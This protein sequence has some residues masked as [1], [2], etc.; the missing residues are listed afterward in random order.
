MSASRD[1][2]LAFAH[3]LLC[4]AVIARGDRRGREALQ[5]P[6]SPAAARALSRL[7][8]SP[9]GMRLAIIVQQRRGELHAAIGDAE[10]SEARERVALWSH[11]VAAGA[12]DHASGTGA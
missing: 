1:A 4:A 9:A 10:A 7:A 2:L 5:R 6:G 8:T 11:A 3:R 12:L